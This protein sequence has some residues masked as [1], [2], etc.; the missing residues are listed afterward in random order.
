MSTTLLLVIPPYYK[1][2]GSFNN[3]VNL[4]ALNLSE[5]FKQNKIKPYILNLDYQEKGTLI[6]RPSIFKNSRSPDK[7]IYSSATRELQQYIDQLKPDY[8]LYCIGDVANPAVDFGSPEIAEYLAGEIKKK[9]PFLF[10]IGYGPFLRKNNI[11]DLNVF[12]QG[13]G[14]ILSHIRNQT[15]GNVYLKC[16]QKDFDR[17]PFLTLDSMIH[18]VAHSDFDYIWYSRGCLHECHFCV[19]PAFSQKQKIYRSTDLFIKE[20]EYRRDH[21]GV[22]DFYITDSTFNSSTL[23]L[24]N[25]CQAIQKADLNVNWRCDCR[26]DLLTPEQLTLLSDAGCTY[27]KL[28]VEAMDNRRLT[29]MNKKFTLET[30][31]KNFKV[32]RQ[33]KLKTVVYILLGHPDYSDDDYQKELSLFKSLKADKYT[34]SI[35]NP[36]PFTHPG[37]KSY[38][39]LNYFPLTSHLN[40][41]WAKVWNLSEETLQKFFDLELA[42]GR[43]D[44]NIRHFRS[45]PIYSKF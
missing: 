28:G 2:F 22:K 15:K 42:C 23:K 17:I 6:L 33:S 3:R 18:P 20:M 25:I 7:T 45:C 37:L 5:I 13:E 8:L 1:F 16:S 29:F 39:H 24:K 12:G 41:L 27:L 14:R 11:F 40:Y 9:N 31:M 19:L 26:I 44:E 43:E 4:G 36:Y 21:Y 30:I 38:S 10:Q 34:V 35:L 32:I